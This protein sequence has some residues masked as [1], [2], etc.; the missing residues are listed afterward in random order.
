[1]VEE[2]SLSPSQSISFPFEVKAIWNFTAKYP[3]E[4]S[5]GAN[6]VIT[7]WKD[8]AELWYKGEYTKETGETLSGLFPKRFV[9]RVGRESLSTQRRNARARY[10]R[11][12]SGVDRCSEKGS[13]KSRGELGVKALT[14]AGVD[15]GG[16]ELFGGFDWFRGYHRGLTGDDAIRVCLRKE[17]GFRVGVGD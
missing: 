14:E 7:V 3:N 6:Q 4:L 2:N 13:N 16:L 9:V 8:E 17:G 12:I 1:M 11:P 10:K 15:A 5:F